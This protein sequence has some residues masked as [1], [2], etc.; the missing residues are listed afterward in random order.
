[1]AVITDIGRDRRRATRRSRL[2]TLTL[3]TAQ[4]HLKHH[5][6]DSYTV[7]S[8]DISTT[9]A[10]I[11][12]PQQ[13]MPAR[14]SRIL[15]TP[16]GAPEYLTI[17]ACVV[18][19][20]PRPSFLEGARGV[21][22]AILSVQT[23]GDTTVLHE[24]LSLVAATD[25]DLA[26]A[27]RAVTRHADRST[28]RPSSTLHSIPLAVH[29]ERLAPERTVPDELGTFEA[30]IVS[31]SIGHERRRFQRQTCS[32]AARWTQ[33]DLPHSGTMLNASRSG[34]FVH[35]DQKLPPIGH[36]LALDL[37][38]TEY[39]FETKIR[40]LGRVSRHWQPGDEGLPGFGLKIETV[41]EHGRTGS[42]WML[43]RTLS[44]RKG[45]PRR[46]FRYRPR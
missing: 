14:G 16:G 30:N 4:P 32:L 35:T 37:V 28:Y 25:S 45:K 39:Q 41:E 20:V 26:V 38:P 7:V 15:L 44:G 10:F 12:I 21:G 31:S 43:L 3:H 13:S 46:G 27:M 8:T 42:Y 18:R 24:W 11:S 19:S 23:N 40:L 5:H 33:N 2:L 22:V 17:E 36:R 1:M 34:L 29:S 9:G 6:N